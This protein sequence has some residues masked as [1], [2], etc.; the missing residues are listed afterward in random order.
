MTYVVQPGD[1]LFDIAAWF[2]LNGFTELFE[3][4]RAVIGDNPDLIRP[5]QTFTILGG[6][7]MQ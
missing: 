5:G 2:E 4:N 3:A 6:Q 7:L 1:R